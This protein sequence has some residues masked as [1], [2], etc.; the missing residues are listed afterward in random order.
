MAWKIPPVRIACDDC[1]IHVGR[2]IRN[3]EIV[4]PGVAYRVHIGEWIEV[5]PA[6]TVRALLGFRPI[7]GIESNGQ[8]T[9]GER[10]DEAERNFD[11]VARSLCDR[12]VAWN[13]T[14][15]DGT[16]LDQPYK[17][18]Q[19]LKDLH[20]DEI[21]YLVAAL[22]R[23]PEAERKNGS[24]ALPITSSRTVRRREKSSSGAS[25]KGLAAPRARR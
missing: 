20:V 24:G 16:A 22:N 1:E 17:A 21:V 8:I 4:T 18:P 12:I 25:A 6:L 2:V 7:E 19:V 5:I 10:L 11:D 3:R 13:W 14:A 15:L 23:E 9:V